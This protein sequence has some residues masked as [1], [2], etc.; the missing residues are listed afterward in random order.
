MMPGGSLAAQ[1]LAV[2]PTRRHALRW[3]FLEPARAE[4]S[5]R[6]RLASMRLFKSV[7]D[8][9]QRWLS[10]FACGC[11][12]RHFLLLKVCRRI[13]SSFLGNRFGLGVTMSGQGAFIAPTAH[14]EPHHGGSVHPFW[15]LDIFRPIWVRDHRLLYSFENRPTFQ[16][17][18][19]LTGKELL[20]LLASAQFPSL[21]EQRLCLLELHLLLFSILWIDDR[22][23]FV[24]TDGRN[25]RV[26]RRAP[27]R[28]LDW[29]ILA[30]SSTQSGRGGCGSAGGS[31]QHVAG[32]EVVAQLTMWRLPTSPPA[33]IVDGL[34]GRWP[35][36]DST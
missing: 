8:I 33:R 34:L 19:F 11:S 16:P 32:E 18:S 6:S 7:L 27:R 35:M 21:F 15:Q 36:A 31:P 4:R 13:D 10:I 9:R 28:G 12:I 17:R 14:A 1:Q 22:D 2:M 30:R 24:A 25:C 29:S 3:V 20:R 26:A 23:H 5:P